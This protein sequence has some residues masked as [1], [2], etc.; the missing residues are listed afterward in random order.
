MAE[1]IIWSFRAIRDRKEIYS[2]WIQRNK[3]DLYSQRLDLLFQRALHL[4]A[5]HPTLGKPTNKPKVRIKIVRDYS[6]IYE[7]R[8]DSIVLLTIWDTRRNPDKL[9]F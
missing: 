7:I 3:S 4:V 2:Y 1:K 5:A 8:E 6:L 9:V